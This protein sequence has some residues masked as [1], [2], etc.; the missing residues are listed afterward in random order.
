MTMIKHSLNDAITSPHNQSPPLGTRFMHNDI[1]SR[2]LQQKTIGLIGYGNQGRPQALNLRDSGHKVLI[3][4]RPN[5]P[6]AQQAALDGFTPQGMTDVVQ[7]SDLIMLMLP[8]DAMETVFT[9][10]I[11][12]HLQPHHIIGVIHGL[13]LISGWLHIPTENAVILAAAKGQGRGV[14]QKFLEGSGVPGLVAIHQHGLQNE[15]TASNTALSIAL[16][17][18]QALGCG[19]SG[20]T[21]TT[22][23]EEAITNLFAEQTILCGGLSHLIQASFDTLIERG[24]SEDI[25][26][27]ECLHE[28]KLLADLIY[29]K[30]LVGMRQAISPTARFGDLTRGPRVIDGH[31]KHTLNL[32][33]DE[34]ESGQ[35]ANE[36]KHEAQNNYLQTKNTL[37][38][39]T[40]HP[41]EAAHKRY[42]A[43]QQ[44]Q[45][46]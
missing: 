40:H 16:E 1:T 12:P 41:I 4:V 7:Q 10:Y 15:T 36:L 44:T 6:S 13:S 8:D 39:H 27:T 32:I 3:G 21:L 35:F 23:K 42:L 14:R 43:K 24:Y 30:G 34:I 29:E 19:H 25:A 2:Y 28:V 38:T 22:P 9:Q 18:L 31:V 5:G 45:S 33:L 46:H 17:Y 20:I 11:Q 26:Y 37:T